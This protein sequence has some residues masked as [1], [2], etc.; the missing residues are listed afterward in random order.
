MGFF[1]YFLWIIISSAIASYAIA[2]EKNIWI[3]TPAIISAA[4]G[5]MCWMTRSLGGI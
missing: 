2:N 3:A 5:C 4:I 1:L